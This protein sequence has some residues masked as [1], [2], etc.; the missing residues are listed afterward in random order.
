M[1]M[2]HIR[3]ARSKFFSP[4]I[5]IGCLF[6]IGCAKLS[7]PPSP[8]QPASPEYTL[9]ILEERQLTS[10]PDVSE[11]PISWSPDGK[12]LAM[13]IFDGISGKNGIYME[14][15]NV[16]NGRKRRLLSPSLFHDFHPIWSPDGKRLVFFSNRSGN[17]DIWSIKS[18]G[19]DLK[20]LTTHTMEDLYGTWSPDG[21]R[22]AFLSTRSKEVAI[23]TM[24]SDGSDHRQLT[25]GGNGDWGASWSPDGARIV[26]G[27]SRLSGLNEP[28]GDQLVLERPRL[29][30]RILVGDIPSE[31]IWIVDV[32]TRSLKK[33]MPEEE[34]G[35]LHWYPAWS[36]DGMKIAYIADDAGSMDIWIMDYDG[37]HPTQLTTSHLYEV[38]PA[39][40]PD[41][42]LLAFASARNSRSITDIRIATLK[43]EPR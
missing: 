4:L 31:A 16:K 20:Q 34:T 41:G 15:L 32:Q 2:A 29:F 27:S 5:A 35:G 22:I 30:E 21:D 40:S 37:A 42:D 13:T 19:S 26:F 39:W 11:Y 17:L 10:T 1:T 28:K 24:K 25:A 38:F 3:T 36:Q 14:I 9:S 33:L 18:N 23:W 43:K 12:Y 8:P 7:S 6:F